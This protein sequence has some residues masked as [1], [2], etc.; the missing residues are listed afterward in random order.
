MNNKTNK[1][2]ALCCE[3]MVRPGCKVIH[4]FRSDVYDMKIINGKLIVCTSNGAYRIGKNNRFRKIKPI[5]P[6]MPNEG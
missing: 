1:A 3:A 2:P 6:A 5:F 4:R